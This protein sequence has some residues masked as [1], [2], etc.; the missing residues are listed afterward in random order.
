LR[1][2]N[3]I[4]DDIKRYL[5]P[6]NVSQGSVKGNPKMH[7]ENAPLRLIISGINHPTENIAEFAEKELEQQNLNNMSSRCHL[8]Y[9]IP[10]I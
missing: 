1:K 8:T 4:T 6:R 2:K 5:L 9:K 7:K 3:Y 10:L